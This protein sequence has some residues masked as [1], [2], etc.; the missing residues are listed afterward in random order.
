[1]KTK[2]T[3]LFNMWY[4]W[5]LLYSLGAPCIYKKNL[6]Q[7]AHHHQQIHYP[8]REM[9][10]NQRIVSKLFAHDLWNKDAS[11]FHFYVMLHLNLH[12]YRTS[13]LNAHYLLGYRQQNLKVEISRSQNRCTSD[14]EMLGQLI[15]VAALLYC[16]YC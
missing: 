10:E 8:G 15:E 12:L 2:P 3:T 1:M 6:S 9:V 5:Q 13:M 16:Y 7:H 14:M 11:H 4:R